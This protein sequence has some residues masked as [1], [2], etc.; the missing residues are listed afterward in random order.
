MRHATR[1]AL[2][3]LAL[4]AG[5]LRASH[6]GDPAMARQA[7]SMRRDNR[8]RQLRAFL[9]AMPKGGDLHSH[10]SGAVYA[11]TLIEAGAAN[12]ACVDPEAAAV[13]K[14]GPRTR[15]MAD[16]L[17]DTE[18]RRT[19]IDAWSMRGFVPSS[20]ISGHDH[21]FDAFAKFGGARTWAQMAADVVDRAGRQHMRYI[22]LMVTFQGRAVTGLAGRCRGPATWRIPSPADCRG[23]AEAAAPP[24]AR[25]RRRRSGA[26]ARCCIAARHRR[27][28]AA[29]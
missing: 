17:D 15:K 2:A 10:L 18:F 9:F 19:L 21:F 20:G 28:P 25:H 16:A 3:C 29:R 24:L 1:I 14:C 23:P 8:R 13:V 5:R 11:E 6:G 26:C 7:G 12:G 22:E 4:L 27:K